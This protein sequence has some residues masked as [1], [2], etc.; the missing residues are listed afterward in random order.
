MS[1]K[2]VLVNLIHPKRECILIFI[3]F[4]VKSTTCKKMNI[5]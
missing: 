5:K 1:E 3:N 2:F 4:G